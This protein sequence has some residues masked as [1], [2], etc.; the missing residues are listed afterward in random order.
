MYNK[1]V[2]ALSILLVNLLLKRR[3]ERV[4]NSY[5]LPNALYLFSGPFIKP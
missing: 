2:N 5:P 4:L 1:S 3:L